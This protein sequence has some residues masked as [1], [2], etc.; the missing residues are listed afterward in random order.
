MSREEQKERSVR[1][2]KIASE[3]R[4]IAIEE[5]S[6]GSEETNLSLAEKNFI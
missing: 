4:T 3:W 6:N 2:K 5:P 1:R